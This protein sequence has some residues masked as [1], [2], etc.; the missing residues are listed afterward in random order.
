MGGLVLARRNAR[1]ATAVN[2]VK[3]STAAGNGGSWATKNV[4]MIHRSSGVFLNS[5][6]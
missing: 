3:A 4:N 1:Q 6:T 2:S 5:S